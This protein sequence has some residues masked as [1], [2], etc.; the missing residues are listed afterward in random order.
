MG[1]DLMKFRGFYK[2]YGYGLDGGKFWNLIFLDEIWYFDCCVLNGR[3]SKI[4]SISFILQF[5]TIPN[6]TAKNLI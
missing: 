5:F 2:N 3:V 6:Y 1:R 4:I